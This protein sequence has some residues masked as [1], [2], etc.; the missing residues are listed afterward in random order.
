[1]WP[2]KERAERMIQATE[3]DFWRKAVGRSR[4]E[5]IGNDRIREIMDV[6]R[7]IVDDIKNKQLIWF[8]HVQRMADTRIPKQKEARKTQ[9]EL[10]GYRLGEEKAWRKDYGMTERGGD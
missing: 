9:E 7:T 3:M 10:A 8:G 4:M 5:K 6:E 2:L 1:M